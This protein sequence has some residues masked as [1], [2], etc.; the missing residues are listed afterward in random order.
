MF[1]L[2]ILSHRFIYNSCKMKRVNYSILI[3][4]FS[5][6][7]MW[8][9][10]EL[11]DQVVIRRTGYGV[12]HI[13]AEN[14]K[15]VAFGLAYA[16]MEDY[17]ERV[18]VPLIQSRGD[19]AKL[20]GEEAIDS[21]A[22]FQLVYE[23]TLATY[24]LLSQKT[25]DLQE[26][27]A[28]GINFYLKQYPDKFPQ[29]QGWTFTGHDVGAAS[30]SITSPGRANSVINRI[31][32]R[33]EKAS[34][35]LTEEGSNAW[36]FGPGRTKSGS[37]ILVRNPHLNWSAGYYEA[38]ITVPGQ[39][40]FYGDFRIGGLFR[41]IGG[42]NER[43]GWTT[44]NNHPDLEEVYAFKADPAKPDHYI[45]D[46]IAIPLERRMVT[47]EFKNGEALALSSREVLSTPYGPV[48]Y[49][50]DGKI[51]VVKAS[52][53]GEYRRGEQFVKMM[54]SQ[55][56]EEWKSAMQMRTITQSNFTYADADANIFYIWNATAPETPHSP[57]GDTT[58]IEVASTSQ[59]WSKIVPFE[60]V[61]QLLNPK[62]GYLHNENDPFHFTN[63]NEVLLP[64]KFP[65]NYPKPRLRQ[66]SQ[67]SLKLIHNEDKYS[68]EEV[69][70]LKHSM[71]MLLADQV[72]DDLINIV[73]ASK[74]KKEIK[75]AITQLENWDNTV[76]PDSRGGVLFKRW[77]IEYRDRTKG[78]EQFA[79]PW[80]FDEPME[81][82]RGL[83]DRDAAMEAFETAVKYLVE[84]YGTWDLAWGDVHRIRHGNLDLPASGGEGGLGCFR[85]FWF[86]DDEDGKQKVR[87]GDGW[88][89]AVEFSDPIKAYS[90]L[91]YGQSNNP[92][93]KHHTDQVALFAD[94]KMKKVAFSEADIKRDL[95][96]EYQPGEN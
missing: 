13:R 93:S 56:L 34:K 19:L 73:K 69:V 57:G 79:I 4:L 64:E 42:F 23:R 75:K 87:G 53:N 65:P 86:E 78:A 81:T 7:I 61:P 77:Y 62:G 63:L 40:N 68:L 72:K 59:I 48:V 49:R 71:G 70:D 1:T 15:A 22:Y 10:S 44:T 16:E 20:E 39:L 51:Y 74:P 85:V 37:S 29:F 24:H 60:S 92:E 17:G 18:V 36:A 47:V 28:A 88:Q 2:T 94:N 45:L 6:S 38:H 82:P 27:F 11:A 25:R 90:I 54:I 52:G 21:D 12:P 26:G 5:S 84:K 31:K 91:A 80:S 67:H 35:S 33:K 76:S 9:Q 8:A 30:T 55:N 95:I 41:I 66:R 43:L 50:D 89:F 83:A 14:F 3:F 46:G 58:A 32:E 96:T